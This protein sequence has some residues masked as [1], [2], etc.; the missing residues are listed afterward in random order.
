MTE[1]PSIPLEDLAEEAHKI[2]EDQKLVYDLAGKRLALRTVE[3][4][5]YLSQPENTFRLAIVGPPNRSKTTYAYSVYS[6]LKKYDLSTHYLDLDLYTESGLAI[7]GMIDWAQRTKRTLEEVGEEK[8][9]ESIKTFGNLKGGIVVGDFPGKIDDPYQTQRLKQT[10]LAIILAKDHEEIKEWSDLCSTLG[11][12]Y[13]WLISET[14]PPLKYEIL[15]PSFYNLTRNVRF[16]PMILVS[17]TSILE[18]IAAIRNITLSNVGAHFSQPERVVLEE[19]L[20]FHFS[21]Q[22]V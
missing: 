18:E 14:E 2:L 20:D 8:I 4:E 6:V 11:V 1:F 10:E 22:N 13:R 3:L 16:S 9:L 21:I 5:A 19:V 12:K 7:S 17:V 15:Y